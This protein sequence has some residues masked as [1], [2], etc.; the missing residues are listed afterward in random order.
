MTRKIAAFDLDNTFFRGRL[1]AELMALLAQRGL[2]DG[3]ERSVAPMRAKWIHREASFEDYESVFDA[4]VNRHL[5][6]VPLAILHEAAQTV[7][8]RAGKRTFTYT[9][10]RFTQLRSQRYVIVAISGALEQIVAPFCRSHGFDAWRG[11]ALDVVGDRLR[12]TYGSLSSTQKADY[13]Q[14]FVAE[15]GCT[16]EDSE[17]FGDTCSDEAVLELVAHPTAFNPNAEL[18]VHAM[19]RGWPIVRES[20]SGVC[21]LVR[22]DGCYVL[23]ENW[24]N[25][26]PKGT[27]DVERPF[28]AVS[29]T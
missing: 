4:A 6:T 29:S 15:F 9:R 17:A 20:D 2:V 22:R 8:A 5:S 12:G 11:Q 14:E 21:R 18:M 10:R 16:L 24:V 13:L 7:V 19:E 3:F 25:P 28:V 27:P 23:D 1:D 26:P